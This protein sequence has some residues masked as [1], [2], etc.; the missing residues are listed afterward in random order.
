MVLALEVPRKIDASS[1]APAR[2]LMPAGLCLHKGQHLEVSVSRPGQ[3][4]LQ[5]MRAD[6]HCP[7][8]EAGAMRATHPMLLLGQSNS[9]AISPGPLEAEASDNDASHPWCT[10][11]LSSYPR[12]E[13]YKT[14]GQT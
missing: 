1:R 10:R 13:M 3:Q 12:R 5:S 7:A 11:L 2:A 6:K 14:Q 8:S 9:S 4:W